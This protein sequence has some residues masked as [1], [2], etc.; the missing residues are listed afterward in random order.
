[1]SEEPIAGLDAEDTNVPAAGRFVVPVPE[2]M[3]AD[4]ETVYAESAEAAAHWDER[5]WR[6]SWR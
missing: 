4:G 5:Y 3:A 1:M 6:N 2:G